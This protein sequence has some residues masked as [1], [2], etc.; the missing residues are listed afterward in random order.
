[1]KYQI[2]WKNGKYWKRL[3]LEWH[4]K[5]AFV[6]IILA[7]VYIL[8]QILRYIGKLQKGEENNGKENNGKE[9]KERHLQ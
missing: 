3:V 4:E 2:T 5:L 1:M 6:V 7:D 8:I 9:N